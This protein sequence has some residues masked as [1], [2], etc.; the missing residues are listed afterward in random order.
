MVQN[1]TG[2]MSP[3]A[4]SLEPTT[5]VFSRKSHW[6]PVSVR[7][8]GKSSRLGPADVK[9]CL[10]PSC[11]CTASKIRSLGE[12]LRQGPP[13]AE[14]KLLVTREQ[15][16]LRSGIAHL[17]VA[18]TEVHVGYII[19]HLK[20]LHKEETRWAGLYHHPNVVFPSVLKMVYHLFS[21]LVILAFLLDLYYY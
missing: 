6:L 5:L 19:V 10:L 3:E 18:S 12:C 20:V 13:L 11:T 4:S 17:E 2:H 21:A 15:G 8:Q 14:G 1:D 7:I 16:L 9:N